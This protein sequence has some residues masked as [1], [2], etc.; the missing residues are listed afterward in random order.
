MLDH[1]DQGAERTRG[2]KTLADYRPQHDFECSSKLCAQCHGTEKFHREILAVLDDP[3]AFQ[4]K[5][6]SCGLDAL[7]K[8]DQF[9]TGRERA[10]AGTAPRPG[11]CQ[12]CGTRTK[13]KVNHPSGPL[14]YACVRERIISEIGSVS[15]PQQEHAVSTSRSAAQKAHSHSD[16]GGRPQDAQKVDEP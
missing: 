10:E 7:L 13:W 12:D 11:R 5:A 16:L 9:D 8:S 3:H 2:M 15:V 4:A 6:C 1:S 14:C